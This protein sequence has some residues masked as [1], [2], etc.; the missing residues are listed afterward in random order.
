MTRRPER[1]LD[2]RA[3]CHWF[4]YRL[5]DEDPVKRTKR[6]TALVSN[7]ARA[8][9]V[10]KI[11][12]LEPGEFIW[13]TLLFGLIATKYGGE[14]RT[15]EVSYTGEMVVEPHALLDSGHMLVTTAQYQPLVLPPLTPET[16]TREAA[17]TRTP[18]GH[19][20]WMEERYS[21]R[22][23]EI[24]LN[25][26]GERRAL[27]VG[28]QAAGLL[29][30][31]PDSS[32]LP[33]I[34]RQRG[35]LGWGP[36]YRQ[37]ALTPHALDPTSFGTRPQIERNRSWAARMNMTQAIQ[38]LAVADFVQKHELV[39]R[40]YRARVARNMPRIWEAVA[41]GTLVAPTLS[42]ESDIEHSFP[43]PDSQVWGEANILTQRVAG[44]PRSS[45]RPPCRGAARAGR[46]DRAAR[47]AAGC[48][49]EGTR[50]RDS[51]G[52]PALRAGPPV[53]RGAWDDPE[54]ARRRR[55]SDQ[56]AESGHRVAR[57]RAQQANR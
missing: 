32:E 18:V 5:L 20:A 55:L 2:E 39:L 3:R 6:R 50:A 41:R 8:V 51:R 48:T 34:R 27:E 33:P 16:T 35:V 11:S 53:Q 23:P 40:W 19:N 38:K 12:E 47:P 57:T 46:A 24:L 25:V 21:W 52:Q 26:V 49:D 28:R 45:C 14:F 42:W 22:V 56:R 37:G 36:D 43:L 10:D 9:P 30:G 4:P 54:A 15:E 1:Q 13:L 29:P 17:D 31:A 7:D 44:G